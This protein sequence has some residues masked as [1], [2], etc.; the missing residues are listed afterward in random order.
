MLASCGSYNEEGFIKGL[1]RKGFTNTR[2]L[3]EIIA[4]SIDAAANICKFVVNDQHI[5]ILD[6]GTGMDENNIINMFDMYRANHLNDKSM[7][8]SGFGA[9]PATA[10]LS[11][12]NGM[13]TEVIIYTHKQNNK[14]YKVIIPWHT[15]TETNKYTGMIQMNEMSIEEQTEF[16]A[17]REK[18]VEKDGCGTTIV[19]IY[20]QDLHNAIEHQFT[21]E[22]KNMALDDRWS[23]IFGKSNINIW[24]TSAEIR[25][26]P[27]ILYDYFSGQRINYYKG[28]NKDTIHHYKDKQNNDRFI[29]VDANNNYN[30]IAKTGRGF[31]KNMSIVTEKTNQWKLIGRYEICIGMRKNKNIFDD[32][33]INNTLTPLSSQ[34]YSICDYDAQFIGTNV[35]KDIIREC[36]CKATIVR[37]GQVIT[38]V[39]ID[40]NKPSSARADAEMM[41]KIFHLRCEILYNTHSSQDNAMD[42]CMGIQENKNQ[43]SGELPIPFS[44]MVGE[45]KMHKYDEIKEYFNDQI[46][47]Y[48]LSL[49]PPTPPPP[50]QLEIVIPAPPPPPLELIIPAPPPLEIVV[51]AQSPTPPPQLEIV[52]PEPPPLEIVIPAPPLEIVIPAPLPPTYTP[53]QDPDPPPIEII[54]PVSTHEIVIP[55]PLPP[56]YKPTQDPEPPQQDPLPPPLLVPVNITPHRRI[57]VL[58]KE[59]IN[60]LQKLINI[61]DPDMAYA[62]DYIKFYNFLQ[63]IN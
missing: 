46:E 54:I 25:L 8:V 32:E 19:F 13:P 62:G 31:A 56:T 33:N 59:L 27:L 5:K 28:C 15:I 63:S 18:E 30:E 35:N 21:E 16:D 23:C 52:I 40:G 51:H 10:I 42:I 55:A 11:K 49:I 53:T 22:S 6:D 48:K 57:C 36:F 37:N 60:E 14:Y 45:L 4:N 20:N 2:C 17:E 44:R 3:A 1:F 26:T 7:G 9:K 24:Y 58:G 41:L 38:R 47:A 34:S 43:H 50:P 29:W 12:L 39:V 61:L